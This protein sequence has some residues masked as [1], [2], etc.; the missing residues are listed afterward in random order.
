MASLPKATASA[1]SFTGTRRALQGLERASLL[2]EVLLTPTSVELH[3]HELALRL[4]QVRRVL[5]RYCGKSAPPIQSKATQRTQPDPR[6]SFCD[7]SAQAY[8][9][10]VDCKGVPWRNP[11]RYAN[12]NLPPR[13]LLEALRQP[14]RPQL[15]DEQVRDIFRRWKLRGE[16]I[17]Y[18]DLNEVA[19]IVAP[20]DELDAAARRRIIAAIERAGIRIRNYDG[21][22]EWIKRTGCSVSLKGEVMIGLIEEGNWRWPERHFDR[23]GTRN[24]N[25]PGNR[26]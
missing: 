15:H 26:G 19:A 11:M 13:H 5:H 8:R 12:S 9:A 25:P 10:V 14:R 1:V 24:K 20:G 2:L 16:P 23:N 17:E 18:A 22:R 3:R 21:L 4:G 6:M 7:T